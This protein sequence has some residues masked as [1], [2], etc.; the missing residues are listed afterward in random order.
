MPIVNTPPTKKRAKLLQF[1]ELTKSFSK[2]MQKNAFLLIFAISD[3]QLPSPFI[4]HPSSF[5][6]HLS[7]F[8]LHLSSFIFHLPLRSR[9]RS[10]IYALY[11]LK[12]RMRIY[13]RRTQG[14]VP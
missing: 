13:L 12:G 6:L 11:L 10:H 9:M 2:K 5:I 1:F 14:C 8:I 7:S 3:Y 4:L